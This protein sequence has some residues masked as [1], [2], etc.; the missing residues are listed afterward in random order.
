[1]I[2]IEDCVSTSRQVQG[3]SP[4]ALGLFYIF[5]L[6]FVSRLSFNPRSVVRLKVAICVPAQCANLCN[7]QQ[8]EFTGKFL[9]SFSQLF[10]CA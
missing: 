3:T 7:L 4:D 1:M 2:A 9:K 10:G 8:L 5:P 6:L